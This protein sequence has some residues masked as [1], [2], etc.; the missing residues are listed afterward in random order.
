MW[1]NLAWSMVR[2]PHMIHWCV[3]N[4]KKTLHDI[5]VCDQWWENH[6]WYTGHT[7][8]SMAREPHMIQLAVI[9]GKITTRYNG[10]WSIVREPHDTI[11]TDTMVRKTEHCEPEAR[12]R[13]YQCGNMR[14]PSSELPFPSK[15]HVDPQIRLHPNIPSQ[16]KQIERLHLHM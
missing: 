10:V 3:I 15:I 2:E 14:V 16:E 13:V 7:V 4:G 8:L 11:G 5:T 1:H 9:N 12:P 6:T